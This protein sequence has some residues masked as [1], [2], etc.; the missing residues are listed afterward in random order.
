MSGNRERGEYESLIFECMRGQQ[1]RFASM[2]EILA[3]W[4]FVDPIETVWAAG[5]PE[6][7]RYMLG[8]NAV[9]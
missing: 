2:R 1:E 3:S 8:A 5:Q 6:L 7:K 4:R 9:I